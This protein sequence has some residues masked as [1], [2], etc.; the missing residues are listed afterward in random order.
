M[1][2][3]KDTTSEN[4]QNGVMFVSK[5]K[6]LAENSSRK[7]IKRNISENDDEYEEIVKYETETRKESNVEMGRIQGSETKRNAN[8][9][10]RKP[11]RVT[12]AKKKT[13]VSIFT[14]KSIFILDQFLKF[15]FLI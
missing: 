4:T 6:L 5:R 2:F 1:F 9:Q 3:R 11:T 15:E 10:Q 13:G 7:R 14:N 8:K 12:S